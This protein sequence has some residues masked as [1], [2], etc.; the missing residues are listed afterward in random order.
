M[1]NPLIKR[2]PR[3]LKSEAGKYIII[4][5][6]MII[7]IGFVSG[8]LVASGSL[9][10]LYNESF[11]KY[12]IEDGNFELHTE[13]DDTVIEAIESDGS[14]RLFKNFYID[15]ETK[16]VDS[17]L[18]IYKNREEIN[19]IC[20]HNGELPANE[21]EIAID[22][23]YADNNSLKV[24]DFLTVGDRK[25][26]ITALVALSDY[27]ALYASPSDMIFDAI[28]FGVAI[29]T[30]DGFDAMG[31]IGFHYNYSW[32][33]NTPPA[34]DIEARKMSEDLLE[35]IS[36][37]TIVTEYIP[38]YSNQAIQFVGDDTGKDRI[39]FTVFL[40]IVVAILAFIMAI[41]TNNTIAK[42]A[43]V[44][45]TLRASGYTRGE[46]IRHYIAMPMLVVVVS[47]II[48]NIIGYTL[49]EGI[50]VNIYYTNYSIPVYV[51][52]PSVDAFV[53]TTVVPAA[54]MLVINY[55]ILAHKLTLSPLKFIRR[56]LKKKQRKKAL[57]LNT[58]I[59]IMHRFRIRIILQ[60]M[61]NYVTIVIGIFLA[62]IILLLG[63]GFPRLLDRNSKLVSENIICDYQY[64]LK[65][66][67]ET[68]NE[69]AEKYC[70][71]SLCT[72]EGRLKSETVTIYGIDPD[73]RYVDIAAENGVYISDA[74]SQKFKVKKGDTITL[75]EEYDTKEYS[76]RIE[77]IY[78]NP[79]TI[80]VYMDKEFFNETFD[81]DKDFFNGYLSDEK[82]DDIDEMYIA[83]VITE[84]DMNKMGRQ[85]THS[86]GGIFD[87]F[88]LFGII[89]FML[90]IYLLSKIV[91]EKN[92]QSI[93]MTK[94]LGYNNAEISG[95]YVISTSIV[96]VLS[97]LL[98]MPIVNMLMKYVCEV[99]F[100]EFSG[101]I[102][103]DVPETVFVNIIASGIIAY[104]VIA[105][106]QFWK[107]KKIPMDMALKN[108][109]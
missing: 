50:A 71:G 15:R 46:L 56:D 18:R 14:I 20:I 66:P 27:S 35:V 94:I 108:V 31:E 38:M 40:Y 77:G 10:K 76:F 54:I 68:E 92:A 64:I 47:A 1:K 12:N 32:K 22:R 97:F 37:N 29:M 42:E 39:V 60:N 57:K 98:T 72:I 96:V 105:F 93:S 69:N 25:L 99:M 13:A 8:F 17:T 84:D 102:A 100:S 43:T 52:E 73:S 6:F 49:F 79:T 61:P 33:Y 9:I 78:D 53:K 2:L 109:E 5:V 85:L 21:N 23:M 44:I 67:V 90:I 65:T 63:M 19:K 82:L 74:Y 55:A 11:E 88:Y 83:A 16:E 62:N 101:W 34:D 51:T 107:L 95:L 87:M 4:F 58:K 75:K 70:A 89:M 103:Y 26:K 30:D 28:K 91:I 48:G 36:E 81:K 45:G 24:G 3:E 41:T 86:M 59:G 7:V 106:A 80:A 104:A